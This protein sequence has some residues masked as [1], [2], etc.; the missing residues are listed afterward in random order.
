[1]MNK[2]DKHAISI[3]PLFW[4]LHETVRQCSVT[5]LKLKLCLIVK[6]PKPLNVQTKYVNSY[7]YYRIYY[8]MS[9]SGFHKVYYGDDGF[10]YVPFFSTPYLQHANVKV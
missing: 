4:L 7:I 1:M 5:T 8:C 10:K 9:F 3:H 2:Q 6:T